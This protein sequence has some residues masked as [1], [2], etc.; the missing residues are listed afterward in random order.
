MKR[1]FSTILISILFIAGCSAQKP[2][3]GAKDAFYF[4]RLLARTVNMGNALEAP[5]EGDWGMKIKKEYF[6]LIK[7]AGFSAVRLPIK[8]SAHAQETIPYTID[9]S[10]LNRIDEVLAQALEQ[11]LSVIL[12][13]H[14]YWELDAEPHKQLKRWLAI[15]AQIGQHYQASPENVFFELLN[16]PHDKFTVDIWNSFLLKGI[17]EIRK[18]NPTRIIIVG[19]T[20]WNAAWRL[21]D[22]KLPENDH[23]I[24]ASF[25]YYDPFAFTHQGAEWVEPSPPTGVTWHEN[26]FSFGSGWENWSWDTSFEAV[27]N[28]LDINFTKGWAGLYLHSNKT[29]SGFDSL[30]F[31]ANKA[32]KLSI[33][34]S[35]DEKQAFQ[36]DTA[37]TQATYS[38]SLKDCGAQKSLDRI[39]IQNYSDSP[40]T[41]SISGL[42]LLGKEK[43]EMLTSTI[44]EQMRTSFE[45]VSDWARAHN[46]P[47]FMGEFGAYNKADLDSRIRWTKFVRKTAEEHDISWSYWEFGAGFGVY[48]RTTKSWNTGIL[49]ALIP[50]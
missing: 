8:W 12:D 37:N 9:E 44:A 41:I 36:L 34:C 38:I 17:A 33:L 11:N 50:K 35:P 10:F 24:I 18:T 29:L 20:F 31:S 27:D 3:K 7:E 40:Q 46:R 43:E 39:I 25:H 15:W 48:N 45:L 4:N 19:P 1:L 32:L 13:F 28:R 23:N 49:N 2:P 14:H 21:K 47:L 16:E 26:D 42:Q 6:R 30:S 22:L 5:V